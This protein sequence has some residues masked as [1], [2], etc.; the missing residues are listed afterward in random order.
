MAH[1]D[2]FHHRHRDALFGPS[3][4][5][6]ELGISVDGGDL[7]LAI[8]GSVRH[9]RMRPGGHSTARDGYR[10]AAMAAPHCDIFLLSARGALFPVAGDPFG[11][12]ISLLSLHAEWCVLGR[13]VDNVFPSTF[14][15]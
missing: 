12:D 5:C 2:P 9:G 13:S 15:K 10:P 8:G 11:P 4:C 1:L 6:L 14:L 7:A 3:P